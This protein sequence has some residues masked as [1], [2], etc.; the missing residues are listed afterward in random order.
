M[1]QLSSNTA[2][3]L[4]TIAAWISWTTLCT[5][6]LSTSS[7]LRLPSWLDIHCP[8]RPMQR[9]A[10]GPYMLLAALLAIMMPSRLDSETTS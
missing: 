7:S 10:F 1:Y 8:C 4:G 6:L 3:P 9:I 5:P 2:L